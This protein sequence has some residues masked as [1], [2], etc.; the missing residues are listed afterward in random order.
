[1][2]SLITS[3]WDSITSEAG[4]VW[5]LGFGSA[6]VIQIFRAGLRWVRRAGGSGSDDYGT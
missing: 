5:C 6:S 4:M 3:A 1:M 2:E